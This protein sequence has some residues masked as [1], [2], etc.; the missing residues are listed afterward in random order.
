[1]KK[2]KISAVSYLNT[3]PFI[4]GMEQ[5]LE[6]LEQIELSKDIPSECARKLIEGEVD[7][8]RLFASGKAFS[9]SCRDRWRPRWYS[10]AASGDNGSDGFLESKDFHALGLSLLYKFGF[11]FDVKVVLLDKK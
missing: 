8:A 9:H 1:L 7:L 3:L 10:S 11:F 6:L 5:N 2:I 4:Y